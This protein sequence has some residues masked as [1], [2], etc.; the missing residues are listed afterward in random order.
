MRTIHT[1]VFQYAELSEDAQS[2]ARDWL[3]EAM[4]GDNDFSESTTDDF[5]ELLAA[6]GFTVDA[7]RGISWSGFSSQGDG[8]SFEGIWNAEQCKPQA[9]L[10][11]RPALYKDAQGNMQTSEHNQAWHCAAAPIIELAKEFPKAS[12]SITARDNRYSHSMTMRLGESYDFQ[13]LWAGV[14][15]GSAEWK[16]HDS[17]NDAAGKRFIEAARDLANV[18]YK[19]LEAEWEYQN[20]DAQIAESIQANEYEFDIGGK[21]I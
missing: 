10:A 12:A 6:L 21:R 18:F 19:N 3:R 2:K 9:L 11:D 13:E 7:K 8:A 4:A 15:Y 17:I 20:A 14:D 16:K 5:R 1:D